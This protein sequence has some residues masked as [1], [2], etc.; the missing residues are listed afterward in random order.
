MKST[1]LRAAHVPAARGVVLEVG[2]GSGLN[3]PFYT[4]AVTTPVRRRSISRVARDGERKTR[5]G[6]VSRR[7]PQLRRRS[8]FRSRDASVDTVVVT[9][10]LCS[11]A[12]DEDALR[13]NASRA[14]T[15]RR[16]DFRRA[17]AFARRRRQEVAKSSD[18][19]LARVRRRLSFESEDGRSG[20]R[21]GFYDRDLRTG[22][23]AGPRALTFMY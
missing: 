19:V 20:A 2:I 15:G 18:A 8:A 7:A 16:V 1:R 11:I 6:A 10:S 22:Y 23:L 12:K 4:S 17:R 5:R 13:R 14:E 21:R 3:L 9:W